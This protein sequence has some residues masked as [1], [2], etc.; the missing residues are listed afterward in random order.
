VHVGQGETATV[1]LTV[2]V[3]ESLRLNKNN[4]GSFRPQINVSD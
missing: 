2:N 4:R 3:R 1:T